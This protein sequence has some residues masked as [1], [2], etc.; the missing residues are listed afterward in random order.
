[1]QSLFMIAV[2]YTPAQTKDEAERGVEPKTQ[3]L[4]EPKWILAKDASAANV[5]AARAIP[6]SHADKADQITLCVRPW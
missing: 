6:E 3:M 2:L 4:V 1:M 5:Q